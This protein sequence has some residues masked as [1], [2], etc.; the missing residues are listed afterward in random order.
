MQKNDETPGGPDGERAD[1][2]KWNVVL[3][4]SF[5]QGA[6]VRESDLPESP[7]VPRRKRVW[8]RNTALALSAAAVTFLALKLT[9][10]SSG[11]EQVTSAPTQSTS[12]S[13]STTPAV[14]VADATR[15]MIPLAQAFPSEVPDGKGGTYTKVA[16]ATL[17]SCTARDSV[18][19]TLIAYIEES[20]GCVGEHIALYKDAQDNQ[21]NLAIFTMKD[22]QDTV[23]IV[24]RL[25]M[26]FDDYQVAAQAPPPDSGLPTL[27]ADSGL[28]QAF[29]GQ[30]RAMVAG[31]AQWSDGAYRDYQGLVD[32]LQPLL[33]EVSARVGE[34]ETTTRP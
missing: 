13:A 32:Q 11:D 24:T 28:V 25:S 1:D 3:D 18:G 22:P 29:T 12:P 9:A 30:G 34:Y 6:A 2:D 10:P 14:A 7:A 15:P 17:E 27:P 21:Y 26:A 16:A 4:E 5:V 23:A 20:Q 8:P 33:K 19:P 31:L